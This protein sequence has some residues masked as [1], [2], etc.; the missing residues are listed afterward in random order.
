MSGR[1]GLARPLRALGAQVTSHVAFGDPAEEIE[2]HTNS[3]GVD[4]ITMASHGRTALA[5]APL[6]KRRRPCSQKGGV[7]PVLLVRPK[8]LA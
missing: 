7:R 2:S 8:D 5:E 1:P 4:V 3:F 6:R